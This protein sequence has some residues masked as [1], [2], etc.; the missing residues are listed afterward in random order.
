MQS[1]VLYVTQITK[2]PGC[3]FWQIPRVKENLKQHT[4]SLTASSE[5]GLDWNTSVTTVWIIRKG[6]LQIHKDTTKGYKHP[7]DV[8]LLGL[9]ATLCSNLKTGAD[10][11]H[12][13]DATGAY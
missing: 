1:K 3:S 11:L 5:E 7:H 6:L 2:L 9:S 10:L 4:K 8:I 13:Q 12:F